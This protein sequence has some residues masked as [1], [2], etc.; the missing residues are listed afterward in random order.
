MKSVFVILTLTASLLTAAPIAPKNVAVLYNSQ[1]AESK[2]LAEFYAKARE[3]P[4]QNLIGLPLPDSAQI[5]RKDYDAKLRDPLRKAF[6]DR[7]WWSMGKTP[8]GKRV[9]ISTKIT[10]LVCMRGVPFKIPRSAISPSKE[11]SKKL[12]ATIAKNNEAAVDSELSA[13]GQYGAPIHGA[14]NNPYYKKDQPFSESGIPFMLLV[15][16]IDAPDFTLCK[17]MITDAIATESRGL[18]GM[19]Y[20]DLAKKGG[21]YAIGDQWL[22]IIAQLNRTTGIPTVI[23]RNKQTFTTNY[24]MND[25]ALYY[26]WYTTHKNGPLLNPEFRFRRG[27][28]AVHLHSYSAS[29]LRNA[30]KNWTGPILAKGAAATVGNIYEPYLHMTHHFDIL[31]DRLLKG[32]SL[33]E[34]AYMAMPMSSWQS[35]VLGDP[36]YRPFIH[37]NGSGKKDPEDRDYRAI[38]IANERWGNDPDHMVKKIRTAAAAKTNAR[39]YE[40]L[41]L[42]H[43][44]QKKP[45]V[46]IAFF[47]TASKKHIKKS[48]R[49]RQWLY[50]ADIHRQN[51]N[52]SLAIATLKKAKETIGNIPESQTTQALLNILDP[53][54]PPPATPKKTS[55]KK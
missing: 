20:L 17:R 8:Q 46:A 2:N 41:G 51:G 42:W 29:N 3:I 54:A 53:P 5:S 33:I 40:Y 16:R 4:M 15:G 27:A 23:D 18:W 55:P 28:I 39:L 35:V 37:L 19:C 30:N 34:A 48:D 22:E 52:K 14:L 45:E 13:L 44:D 32:Y 1:I 24:P 26:G 10:T 7:G 50:T 38:R 21:G 6:I 43:R 49:L 31:H 47:Q 12:P 36:L 9:T 25:A 11:T